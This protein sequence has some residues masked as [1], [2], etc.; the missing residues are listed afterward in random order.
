VENGRVFFEGVEMYLSTPLNAFVIV[1][2]LE[3]DKS[4]VD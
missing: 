2:G 3:G 1:V 4:G